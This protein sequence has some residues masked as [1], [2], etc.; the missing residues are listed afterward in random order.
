MADA[1]SK[2]ESPHAL[3]ADEAL[4]VDARHTYLRT[5][6]VN[7]PGTFYWAMAALADEVR[8]LRGA[9]ETADEL[10]KVDELLQTMIVGAQVYVDA[11]QTI[12]AYKI[13]TGALHKLAGLRSVLFFPQNLPL[14]E[15][16]APRSPNVAAPADPVLDQLISD[17]GVSK[18]LSF[19][20][21]RAILRLL[22]ELK[23]QRSAEMFDGRPRD[24]QSG[25]LL[26]QNMPTPLAPR[27]GCHCMACDEMRSQVKTSGALAPD[28]QDAHEL[29]AGDVP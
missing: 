25:A 24:S 16:S 9:S 17:I 13:K 15:T 5:L 18:F 10:T 8:R 14:A 26:C 4:L 29:G 6:P 28:S 12:T 27:P 20:D 1:P 2:D 11:E 19:S 3:N 23:E 7:S 22:K 21:H